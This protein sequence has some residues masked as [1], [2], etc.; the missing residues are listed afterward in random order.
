MSGEPDI[1]TLPFNLIDKFTKTV[2]STYNKNN[3]SRPVHKSGVY[4]KSHFSSYVLRLVS[5]AIPI[6]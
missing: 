4:M 1:L 6:I 5:A 2:K 3:H